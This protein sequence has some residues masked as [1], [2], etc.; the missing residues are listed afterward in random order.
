MNYPI[1]FGLA[2]STVA[3]VPKVADEIGKRL[4]VPPAPQ[5]P[6]VMTYDLT[7]GAYAFSYTVSDLIATVAII[8]TLIFLTIA[9]IKF[10]RNDEPKLKRR[11]GDKS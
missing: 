1:G 3:I 10:R 4:P 5:P 7:H 2:S 6:S 11:E 9:V 8:S